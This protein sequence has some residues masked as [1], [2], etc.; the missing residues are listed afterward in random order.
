ME[1]EK[2]EKRGV[3]KIFHPALKNEA[4]KL[5]AEEK[6]VFEEIQELNEKMDV[7][8]DMVSQ[9]ILN[10]DFEKNI[11]DKLHKELQDYKDDLYFQLIKPLIM[12]LINMRE[13]M[14]RA[15]KHSS[16]ETDEKKVEMLESYVEEIETI[17]E[18][19]NIEIYETKK[20]KDD[21]KVKKQRIVKQ[22]KTSDEKLH[23]KICNI[24]TNGYIY[25]EK[26]K[27]IFPEKVEVYVYKNN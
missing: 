1:A 15:V 25:T 24:L 10:I 22:I 6:S 13:R 27:I 9:K 4:V 20:E 26:N 12:D 2:I 3:S 17:L 8:N 18:N 21:Y 19:N 7:M 14:R 16:K 11:V 23:G 5:D